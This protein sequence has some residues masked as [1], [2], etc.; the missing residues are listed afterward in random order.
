MLHVDF[1]TTFQEVKHD[2]NDNKKLPQSAS[3][4]LR[5]CNS[6]VPEF[7]E[8]NLQ[9]EG[10]KVRYIK[11]HPD[12][13]CPSYDGISERIRNVQ[14][15]LLSCN[16][17]ENP[18][19][20]LFGQN[21]EPEDFLKEDRSRQCYDYKQN[22]NKCRDKCVTIVR[23]NPICN[24]TETDVT[25]DGRQDFGEHFGYCFDCCFQENCTCSSCACSLYNALCIDSQL[26]CVETE[27]FSIPINPVFPSLGKFKCHVE[28]SRG[29]VF[30]METTLWKDGKMLKRIENNDRNKSQEDVNEHD[31]GYMVLKHPSVLRNGVT[32][33]IMIS[34]QAGKTN[35]DVGWY[36]TEQELKP[37]SATQKLSIQPKEPF[38]INSND[39]A[40]ENCLNFDTERFI[41]ISSSKPINNFKKFSKL[42]ASITY[43]QNTRVY[44]VYNNSG[45][46]QVHV[47]L[48]QGRSVLRYTFPETVIFNDRSFTGQLL[49][50]RTFWTIRFTG[51]VTSCPGFFVVRLTDQ[52]RPEVDVYHYDIGE[53]S[54]QLA[55]SQFNTVDCLLCHFN[56]RPHFHSVFL[57]SKSG[58]WSGTRLIEL[59]KEKCFK[60]FHIKVQ[61]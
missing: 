38:K 61:H 22:C 7:Y 20:R 17:A 24:L 48:P 9:R 43:L 50:N 25:R 27:G 5:Y 39:W 45:P 60:A 34:G 57:I 16:G 2:V 33:M 55:F 3:S 40:H 31:Y 42:S 41:T 54:F 29:P 12:R 59:I 35:F 28:L 51:R 52:D 1:S 30:E 8:I 19:V 6:P 10:K 21:S 36:E 53:F 4:I 47:E 44:K 32:K 15:N 11:G 26:T 13:T 58:W 18:V 49:K 37:S 56:C 14:G 46:R 23:E